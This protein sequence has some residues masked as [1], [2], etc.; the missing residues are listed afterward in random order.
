[1]HCVGLEEWRKVVSGER[2]LGRRNETIWRK[3]EIWDSRSSLPKNCFQPSESVSYLP[4]LLDLLSP[5]RRE[6]VG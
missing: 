4:N 1:M 2:L 5:S 3:T 6:V